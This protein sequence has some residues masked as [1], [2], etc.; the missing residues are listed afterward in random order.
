VFLENN[1]VVGM[2]KQEL[3]HKEENLSMEKDQLDPP[4]L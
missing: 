3:P 1:L 2:N 4:K